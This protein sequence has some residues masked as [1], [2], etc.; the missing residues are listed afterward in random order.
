[1][2]N[3][4]LQREQNTLPLNLHLIALNKNYGNYF[5]IPRSS[6]HLNAGL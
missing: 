6:K 5:Y 2:E 1:M 4:L 3:A